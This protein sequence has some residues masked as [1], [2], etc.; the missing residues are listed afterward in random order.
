[1]RHSFG[2]GHILHLCEVCAEVE[3]PTEYQL[4]SPSVRGMFKRLGKVATSPSAL[5]RRAF[6]LT[7]QGIEMSVARL[8]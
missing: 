7:H 6:P 3:K 5:G 8:L 1:M 2:Q 4:C